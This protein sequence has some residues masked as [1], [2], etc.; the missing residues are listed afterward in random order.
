MIFFNR[1][2]VIF[3]THGKIRSA[4]FSSRGK[5]IG[6]LKTYDWT[7]ESLPSVLKNIASDGPNRTR[8]VFGEEFSY[9]TALEIDDKDRN[10]I[11]EKSSQIIPE[12]LDDNW[13]FKKEKDPDLLSQVAAVGY[14]F[15]DFFSANME[16][17]GLVTESAEPQSIALTRLLP[18]PGSYIFVSSDDKIVLGAVRNGVI[19]TT[20]VAEIEKAI[21]E[22]NRFLLFVRGKF[23]FQPDKILVG[24]GINP[25]SAVF[26]ENH[27][28]VEPLNLD[29]LRGTAMK[30]DLIGQDKNILN[31]FWK[32]R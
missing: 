32:K 8:V 19:L 14:D 5:I 20:Y 11:A 18:R 3:V 17:A 6:K 13:D 22:F 10:I 16:K 28:Q 29:P 1:F 25:E 27:L 4:V 31:I 24:E 23:N 26:S 9:V 15:F 2:T 21:D 30:R 12:K 7:K